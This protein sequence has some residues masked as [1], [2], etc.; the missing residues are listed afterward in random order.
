MRKALTTV[1][2]VSSVA[3]IG[4]EL[5]MVVL[6]LVAIRTTD[7]AL[8]SAVYTLLGTLVPSM[9]IPLFLVALASGVT[10]S[11]RTRWGLFRHYWVT[12][13]LVLLLATAIIGA[14]WVSRWAE[15]LALDTRPALQAAHLGGVLV[16]LTA[17][18]VA[19]TLSV[20]KPR[21]EWRGTSRRARAGAGA[22]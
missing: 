17:L 9:G 4:Q 10:L 18:T 13:K 21:G 8:A 2:I 6:A 22:S 11:L 3:L 16:Q 5:V 19:A 7:P 15:Q 14:V 20:Y 12:A 1:H